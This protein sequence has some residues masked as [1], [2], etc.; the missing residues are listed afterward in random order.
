MLCGAGHQASLSA[1]TCV[2]WTART[3]NGEN[4]KI[5]SQYLP[6]GTEESHETFRSQE[7]NP[8]RASHSEP[9]EHKSGVRMRKNTL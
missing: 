9:P 5:R 1:I 4:M 7:L 8:G 3:G 2:H 6:M